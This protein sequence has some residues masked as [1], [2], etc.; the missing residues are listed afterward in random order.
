MTER[1]GKL[2]EAITC[3]FAKSITT[4]L[5]P[6]PFSPPNNTDLLVFSSRLSFRSYFAFPDSCFREIQATKRHR[7][8]SAWMLPKLLKD[9][10]SAE[11]GPPVCS[12]R[13]T[14]AQG[15]HPGPELEVR[16]RGRRKPRAVAT[17]GPSNRSLSYFLTASGWVPQLIPSGGAQTQLYLSHPGSHPSEDV[18][19]P[20]LGL[21]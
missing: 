3:N 1:R 17:H 10:L 20:S 6:C 8:A 16:F 21:F 7:V 18:F 19:M 5:F 15:W 4:F 9:L 2:C 14:P 11:Q 12:G 13:A